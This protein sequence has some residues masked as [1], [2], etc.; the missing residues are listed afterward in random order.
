MSKAQMVLER[1]DGIKAGKTFCARD[2]SDIAGNQVVGTILSRLQASGE[3]KRAVRGVYY[4]ELVSSFWGF[5]VPPDINDVAYTIARSHGWTIAPG[6]DASLNMVHLD[7]Q[8]PNKQIFVSTGP[9]TEYDYE[10]STIQFKHRSARYLE[11]LS[12][13]SAVLTQ[14]LYAAGKNAFDDKTI[15][16]M[17]SHLSFEQVDKFAQE[18]SRLPSWMITV[19]R[20]LKEA[21]HA[22]AGEVG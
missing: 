17:T 3:I 16:N 9:S 5:V 8:V 20:K 14:A 12:P 18:S 15:R 11:G 22:M 7:T 21:K 2:F 4:K 1:I 19:S 13:V 6:D 10:R